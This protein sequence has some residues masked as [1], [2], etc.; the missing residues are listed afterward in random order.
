MARRKQKQD[1]GPIPLVIA[2]VIVGSF[3][4]MTS[5][6]ED[7][8]ARWWPLLAGVTLVIVALLIWRLYVLR[9]CRRA[10]KAQQ[11]GFDRHISTTDTMTGA[12]FEQLVR[13]LLVRDGW[14]DV[15]VSGGAGDLGADVTAYHP[16]DG[17]RLV[18]QCK[19]YGRKSVS[20]PDMQRFLGTVYDVHAAG[21]AMF[22]TT[23]NYTAP[24]EQLGLRQKIVLVDR[25]VLA[26]WM[27][28]QVTPIM[29]APATQSRKAS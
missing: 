4:G 25:D 8:L 1:D 24:A 29:L 19:R 10:R 6:L 26:R 9:S 16:R 2:L 13:R 17:T 5:K 22:V 7:A 11:A 28:G 15:S 12:E 18:V 14:R 21:R 20:S 27:A 23:S 3:T